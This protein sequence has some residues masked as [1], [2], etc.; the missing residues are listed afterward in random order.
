MENKM[1][2]EKITYKILYYTQ[3]TT[4]TFQESKNEK[5]IIVNYVAGE[6][7]QFN[8]LQDFNLDLV[9]DEFKGSYVNYDIAKVE[10]DFY[11]NVYS[12][13]RQGKRLKLKNTKKGWTYEEILPPKEQIIQELKLEAVNK[14]DNIEFTVILDGF[15]SNNNAVQ[16]TII[17]NNSTRLNLKEKEF[18]LDMGVDA[19]WGLSNEFKLTKEHFDLIRKEGREFENKIKDDLRKKIDEINNE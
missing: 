11:N 1:I 18:D 3:D 9:Y 5:P 7:F 8:G 19:F 10:E 2:D 6:A 4:I 15:N 17:V 12:L 13:S 16:K 14:L